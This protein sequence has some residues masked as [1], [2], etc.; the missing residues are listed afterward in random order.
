[1]LGCLVIFQPVL[2][3]LHTMSSYVLITICLNFVQVFY[4]YNKCR[5]HI[6]YKLVGLTFHEHIRIFL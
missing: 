3:M 1:M 6:I 5:L 4:T 2:I